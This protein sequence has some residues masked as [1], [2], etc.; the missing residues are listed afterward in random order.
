MKHDD[1]NCAHR[2]VLKSTYRTYVNDF[3]TTSAFAEWLGIPKPFAVE[4][5]RI[6]KV[7]SEEDGDLT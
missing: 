5:I 3:I 4:L 1:Q 7:L 6:G 2:E